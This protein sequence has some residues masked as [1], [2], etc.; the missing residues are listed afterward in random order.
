MRMIRFNTVGLLLGV[1]LLVGCEDDDGGSSPVGNV[2]GSWTWSS[3]TITGDSLDEP[4]TVTPG[5][6]ATL[7]YSFSLTAT[8]NTDATFSAA[9]NIPDLTQLRNT[10]IALGYDVPV[11]FLDLAGTYNING[12]WSTESDQMTLVVPDG[13]YA[14]TYVLSYAVSGNTLTL[15]IPSSITGLVSGLEGVSLIVQMSRL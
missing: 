2:P 15:T 14:G 8:F 10:L 11:S 13:E 3:I 4:V 9:A 12:T 1:I 5:Q 7:G 6:L